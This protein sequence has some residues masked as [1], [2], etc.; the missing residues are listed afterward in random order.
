[1]CA[2][3]S[4]LSGRLCLSYKPLLAMVLWYDSGDR[5]DLFQV[6]PYDTVSSASPNLSFSC[7]QILALA[8]IT[9]LDAS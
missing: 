4:G 2:D 8:D 6:D 3:Q 5:M 9:R 1:M 7:P